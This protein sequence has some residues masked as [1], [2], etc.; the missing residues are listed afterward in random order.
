MM[1]VLVLCEYPS[2]NGGEHSLLEVAKCLDRQR[3]EL[4]FAAPPLGPLA[5]VLQREGWPHLPWLCTECRANGCRQRDC[6]SIW[7][8]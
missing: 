5:E 2:L 3:V 8:N 7:P 6:V 4:I 1:R